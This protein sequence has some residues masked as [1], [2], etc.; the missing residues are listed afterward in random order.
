MHAKLWIT[1]V[2][3]N[4]FCFCMPSWRRNSQHQLLMISISIRFSLESPNTEKI[5]SSR[6][7]IHPENQSLHPSHYL[8]NRISN[9][10][11]ETIDKWLLHGLTAPVTV[12]ISSQARC[13]LRDL[14][15]G[16]VSRQTSVDVSS[17][18]E[19]SQTN[20]INVQGRKVKQATIL[21]YT[22]YFSI[23]WIGCIKMPFSILNG[24]QPMHLSRGEKTQWTIRQNR[25]DVEVCQ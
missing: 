6:S 21:Y 2:S 7:F 10:L 3:C 1:S 4:I 25:H 22:I 11:K 19:E 5:R 23:L 17:M 12:I 20:A 18:V 16:F 15:K 13:R 14:T 24:M 8:S 9:L